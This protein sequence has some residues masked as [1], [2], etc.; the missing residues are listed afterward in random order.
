MIYRS[1]GRCV[2]LAALVLSLVALPAPA[3]A[4]REQGSVPLLLRVDSLVE[5][6]RDWLS[7]VVR[8]SPEGRKCGGGIDPNGKPCP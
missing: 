2:V 5:S 1:T 6:L 3:Q 8:T 7:R 4:A